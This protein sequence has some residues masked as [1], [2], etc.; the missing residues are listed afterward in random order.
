MKT[1]PLLIGNWKMN[2]TP[3]E[4]ARYAQSLRDGIPP[5]TKAEVWVAPMAVCL[6]HVVQALQGSRIR[7]GAQNVHWAN[8]GAFTGEISPAALVDIGAHFAIVGHSERRT[9]F[10]ET[11][12][13][14]ANRMQAALSAGITPVV[15]IGET[16][17]QRSG[18]ETTRVL[19]EQLT[20]LFA[21]LTSQTAP[22][23]VLAYEPVWAIGTG[24][25]ASEQEI[26]DTHRYIREL[27][28]AQGF[29]ANAVILYGGSVNPQNVRGI[30]Q[31]AGVDGA[32]VGGAS[33]KLEQWIELVS[34]AEQ[35]QP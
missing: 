28:D 5:R 35:S 6:A 18:G 3:S 4:A 23:V 16:D 34:L 11:S 7:V 9:Y 33:I 27:W 19:A 1:A 8:S 20:P 26:S 21:R 12:E 24:K 13:T 10:G 2:L 31:I 25:V 14:V 15:C 17:A 29:G 32:L 30:M 22:H